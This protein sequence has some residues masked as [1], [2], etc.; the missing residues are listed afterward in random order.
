MHGLAS[1]IVMTGAG[2]KVGANLEEI[3]DEIVRVVGQAF[4]G[5]YVS[6]VHWLGRS[7]DSQVNLQKPQ[8]SHNPCEVQRGLIETNQRLERLCDWLSVSCRC[9]NSDRTHGR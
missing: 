1:Q 3:F 5:V 4:C 7:V 8:S 9:D 2:I 6:V